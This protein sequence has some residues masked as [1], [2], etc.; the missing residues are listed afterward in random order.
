MSSKPS[1]RIHLLQEYLKKQNA[2]AAVIPS[3]DPHMSEYVA[4]RWR[5]RSWISAFEGSAGTVAV[6]Q[7]DAALWTD[8]RYFLEAGRVLKNSGIALMKQGLP[9]T[10]SIE[11]W[12]MQMKGKQEGARVLVAADSFALKSFESM[13]SELANGDISLEAAPDFL[14]TIWEN[15]PGL[16][17]EEIYAH[18]STFSGETR[19]DRITRLREFADSRGYER[20]L[21]TA[22]DEIAWL[23]QLRGRDVEFNPVF[24]AYALLETRGPVL[25]LCTHA[26]NISPDLRRELEADNVHIHGYQDIGKLLTSSEGQVAADPLTLNM[27]TASILGD[28]LVKLPSP[29]R[30]WKACKNPK[31]I[32]STRNVM[33]RDGVAMVNF[34]YWL[35]HELKD[36][37]SLDELAVS[38]KITEFR[39][40]QK[41]YV[42]DSFRSIV[43]FNDH[44]AVVHYSV[45]ENSSSPIQGNGLLLIDSGGQ[46]LDGTTDITRTVA[47]HDVDREAKHHFTLVLKGHINLASAVFPEGTPGIQLDSLARR[48]LWQNGLNYG[49][50][51]GHGV[52]FALN[53]HEGPQSISPRLISTPLQ[54]GMICSNEP[55]YYLEGAY[56]IRI[57]NLVAVGPHESYSGFLCF[58]D[59]TLCPIELSL[60]E[61]DLLND[62]EISWLN[63]YHD[64]V[65][66]NL[67]PHLEQEQRIWLQHKTRKLQRRE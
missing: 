24:Y 52:G 66:R 27:E 21:I 39:S 42:G 53:V 28:R 12:L 34:L 13:Q 4:E 41:N 59:L 17:A 20:I 65:W 22:L 49:H 46:Y 58:E 45:D 57:E 25:H 31:E 51:T 19:N 56:G 26:E 18:D 11:Q 29:V 36:G 38:R 15:R 35:E 10:P 55:G 44:G 60:I 62:E 8:S 9:E 37:S 16:P 33:I 3:T 43:G 67:S 32:E 7:K 2:F 6:T 23:L 50:G 63:D 30:S 54:P 1:E 64:M 14:D 48:P 47:V 40:T 5:G 61:R